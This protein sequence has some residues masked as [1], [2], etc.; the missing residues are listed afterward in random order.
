[1]IYHNTKTIFAHILNRQTNIFCVW[2][3]AYLEL[4]SKCLK[5]YMCYSDYDVTPGGGGGGA[6][7][8]FTAWISFTSIIKYGTVL[9]LYSRTS[10][11]ATVEV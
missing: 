8:L 6:F 2:H 5:I 10:E 11:G 4:K 3:H 9:L 1:M 7:T